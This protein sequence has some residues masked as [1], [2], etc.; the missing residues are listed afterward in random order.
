MTESD[1][2]TAAITALVSAL[3]Q[4]IRDQSPPP[5]PEPRRPEETTADTATS[6]PRTLTPDSLLT[7]QEAMAEL[8]IGRTHLY[9]LMG[10]GRLRSIKLGSRTLIQYRDLLRFI[11]ELLAD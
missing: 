5:P 2:I 11:D 8:R 4:E 1:P 10:Q 7:V 3:R 9:Q 6:A